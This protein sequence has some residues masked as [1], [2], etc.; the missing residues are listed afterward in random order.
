MNASNTISKSGRNKRPTERMQSY[1]DDKTSSRVRYRKP[2]DNS[3]SSHPNEGYGDSELSSVR[4]K[5]KRKKLK[6]YTCSH[7]G[8]TE[9]KKS[10]QDFIKSH[11]LMK[12]NEIC[13]KSGLVH[14]PN[15]ECSKL[16]L[17]EKDMESHCTMSG[18]SKSKCLH[19]YRKSK[20]MIMQ[21][22][23]HATSQI[24]FPAIHPHQK[25]G[26][27]SSNLIQ[28]IGTLFHQQHISMLDGTNPP[29][30]DVTAMSHHHNILLAQGFDVLR[31]MPMLESNSARHESTPSPI[32]LNQYSSVFNPPGGDS[33]LLPSGISNGDECIDFSTDIDYRENPVADNT[34][35]QN[36]PN[37]ILVKLQTVMTVAAMNS[38]YTREE[39]AC[40][41]LESILV[42]AGTPLYVYDEVMN[43]AK[44]NKNRIPSIVPIINRKLLYDRLSYKM[45]GDQSSKFQ[46]YE[47][48]TTLPS[49]R[50][51]GVTV[52]DIRSQIVMLLKHS[53]INDWG[54]YFFSPTR[55]DPFHIN[56]FTDWEDGN[57]EDIESSIWYKRTQRSAI[58]NPDNEILVPICLFIDGT[59]LSL[60][61][62]LSLEPVM[63]SLMIHNRETRKRPEAWLPLGYINDPSSMPGKKFRDTTEK[64]EDYHAMLSI[65]L[66]G[67]SDVVDKSNDG[68]T[69]TFNKVP[70]HKNGIQKLLK[71]RLAFIIGDTKG[72]DVLCCRMG[73]HYNTIGLCRDC[74]MTT[75]MADDP[76]AHCSFLKQ[77]EL[78]LKTTEELRSMSFHP[79]PNN[80]VF[81]KLEFGQS[82]YGVNGATAIDVLHGILLGILSYLYSTFKDHLTANQYKK[83]SDIVAFIATYCSKRIPGFPEISYWKKGLDRKGILTAQM[84]LSRCFLVY[85]ALNT[86]TF[87]DYMRNTMGK[88]PAA[89]LKKKKSTK[90]VD[91]DPDDEEN[92]NEE[93]SVIDDC[94]MEDINKEDAVGHEHINDNEDDGIASVTSNVFYPFDSGLSD[95]SGD[96]SYNPY[97][98]MESM[99]AITF[100]EDVYKFWM[101]LFENSL[102]L[103][104]FMTQ[105]ILPCIAFK[106]GSLSMVR[107]CLDTYMTQY[108]EVA[109]RFDG[110]GLKLT[111]FHQLRHWYFYITMYGV[112]KTFDSAFC[113]SNHITLTKKTGRRTQ[114]R[115][116][117]LASQT[118]VRVYESSMLSHALHD[119]ATCIGKR[120]KHHG[121]PSKQSD[122][123]GNDKLRGAKFSLYFDYSQYD[124]EI[125][126]LCHHT[127][128]DIF[129]SRAA[130][131]FSWKNKRHKKRGTFSK[132]I[133]SAISDKL[134]WF[135]NGEAQHR[136]VSIS[137]STEIRLSTVSDGGRD[138]IRA[139]PD[140][141]REG[142]WMDWINV[143]WE[144][145]DVAQ[146][147]VNVLPAQVI[148]ILD[149]D[150]AEY[151][152]LPADIHD[153]LPRII[154]LEQTGNHV[155]RS[156]IHVVIHSAAEHAEDGD[157]KNHVATRY[158]ME[159]CFQLIQKENIVGI[160]FVARDPIMPQRDPFDYEISTVLTG[161][162]WAWHFIPLNSRGYQNWYEDNEESL[163]DDFDENNISW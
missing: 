148:M 135:N 99:D 41:E 155:P 54:N 152:A 113:E 69:W 94:V 72:H 2:E 119:T 128:N 6:S 153:R 50:R 138:I 143:C 82:P 59:V 57:F 147:H 161:K 38:C 15:P 32:A 29:V 68:F 3:D 53:A 127:I 98:D 56:T 96:S 134:C 55:N 144:N 1:L 34:E 71:F 156:G 159:N 160:A 114:K 43:W 80:Y 73:S 121:S 109:Y 104:G 84:I 116:D 133:L 131:L 27:V 67:L 79:L 150:T 130:L 163:L 125:K 85:L 13:F 40:L 145:N 26:D 77:K 18:S 11:H 66:K 87:K 17:T 35:V 154:D 92:R 139:H 132:L 126:A 8:H 93:D 44:R 95:S 106:F 83:L 22:D 111:K 61:G 88:L 81:R 149:F 12:G 16:C 48:P 112:P 70:G 78:M 76:K 65:V 62:S 7:C 97:E 4:S 10:V 129:S 157:K 9:E 89:I 52:F 120:H 46:P 24:D 21:V 42:S 115:Q 137:G 58:T 110:M 45:F 60:S 36:M 33:F 141:R 108:R 20:S 64:L 117:T 86:A 162:D 105:D 31:T 75:V 14:C 90:K 146:N 100:T 102:L 5:K 103:H 28:D 140:Y 118:A 30:S 25:H 91:S 37:N 63:F 74:D 151:E 23:R 49:G 39:K 124:E 142:L 123:T 51:C 158:R 136:L 107:Y 47:V 122:V 101:N 19:Y